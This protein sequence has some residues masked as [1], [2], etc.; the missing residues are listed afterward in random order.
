MGLLNGNPVRLLRKGKLKVAVYGLGHVGV[1]VMAVW[2]RAGAHVIG[3]DKSD[4]VIRNVLKGRSH[5][6]EP[7]VEETFSKAI[8]QDRLE[9][10]TDLVYASRESN[11][12]IITVPVGFNNGVTD[13]FAVKEVAE[14]IAKGLK[15]TDVV[16]LNATVPPGTT[17]EFLL[18]ILE[19]HCGLQCEKQFGLIYTPE[20]IY[21]GRAIKDIEDNYPSIVAGIGPRSLRVGAALYSFVAKKGVIKM[22]S[23][24]VTEFTKICEG[25]YR[26]VNIA[27]A[28]ELA[29]VAEQ[30]KVDCWEARAASNSQPFC[31]IHKPGIGVGGACIPVYPHFL[32]EVANKLKQQCDIVKITRKIN[33]SMPAYCVENAVE[34]MRIAGKDISNSNVAI[35]GLAFR[36]EVED[37][38]LSPTYD[39]INEL[40]ALGCRIV[41]HDPY[42]KEDEKIPEQVKLTNDLSYTLTNADLV[43]VATDH[44]KYSKLTKKT[45]EKYVTDPVVVYDGRGILTESKFRGTFFGSI[46]RGYNANLRQS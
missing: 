6:K 20:R 37:T 21:E 33:L 9:A 11:F 32:I 39:I 13:L 24:R 5:I 8:S 1:P 4:I 10:T 3:V 19:K 34:L 29:K 38:R 27:L 30:L 12:K 17:E 26:D 41:V 28:N 25:V 18:P 14:S 42:V 15:D 43:I 44:K 16:S 2:L 7:G 45:I 36:S 22:S 46:G 23:I 40:L 35:L 31:N